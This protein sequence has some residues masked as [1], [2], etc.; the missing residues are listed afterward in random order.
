MVFNPPTILPFPPANGSPLPPPADVDLPDPDQPITTRD[1]ATLKIELGDG[2]AVID[3][4]P[5]QGDKP[6][7]DRFNANLALEMDDAE[8]SKISSD[9]L[10]GIQ[11][12][13]DSRTDQLAQLAKGIEL[14]GFVVEQSRTD[15]ATSTSPVE[16]MSTVRHPLLADACINFNATARGE[17]LPASGPVKVRD[18]R[19]S[20]PIGLGHNGGP[21]LEALPAATSPQLALGA[22]PGGV[23]PPA[24]AQPR[25]QLADA[26]EKDMN[27]Y[28]TTTASEYYPDTDQM[29]FRVG[30]GGWGIKKVYNCP[31]RRRPV[32]ES[33]N[34]DDFIVSN[35]A[36]D[37]GN[38]ARKTHRIKMR[39]STLRRMQILGVYRDD[40]IGEPELP[41]NQQNPVKEAI[42]QITGI[43]PMVQDRKDANHELDECYCELDL[44]KF[45]PTQFKNKGLPL[46][47]RV[48]IERSSKKIFE[49]RRNWKE[50]DKECR[51][52]EY[53][54]EFWFIKAFG[55]YGVGLLH[56]LGNTTKALTSIWRELIDAGS[57]AN[58]PGF[59][60]A[61]GAGRQLTNQFRVGPGQ[62]VGLDIGLQK[63]SDVVMALPYKD[64]SQAFSAFATHIEQLGMKLGGTAQIAVGEGRQD[65]PVGTTLALI[66]QATKPTSAVIKR[67]YSSQA[68]EMQ[69]LKERFREDPEAFWRFNSRPAMKWQKDQFLK[70]LDDFEL[71][72]VSDPNNPT[73]LH[74]A[75]KSEWVKQA[76]IAAGPG[77]VDPRKA[78][79]RS[80]QYVEVDD[81][82]DLLAA[83]LPPQQ[84]PVDPAKMADIAAKQEK[85]KTDAASAALK[86]QS[87]ITQAQMAHTA[88][89]AEI[90]A[91]TDLER[92][93]L[94][95]TMLIHSDKAEQVDRILHTK[96]AS[97][98]ALD[99]TR[100]VHE[101]HIQGRDHAHQAEQSDRDRQ[102]QLAQPPQEPQP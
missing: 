57:F 63:L 10:A 30:F 37:L 13:E 5:G 97:E 55:F 36:T 26:L 47:Y 54:V 99:T 24:G 50:D 28:L 46:P 12:D 65:A 7:S 27:H 87:D 70:A 100:R 73:H 22:I 95:Q 25:D 41:D 31:L 43:Q 18:D 61:K 77:V 11:S 72:P 96:L 76:A 64:V 56:I 88:R 67:L 16:D 38:A 101:M 49:L 62:G 83:P 75:A 91:E 44:D 19:P 58:F 40:K 45:A 69:L 21:P 84:P 74:R 68:K 34:T 33:I 4:N 89:M 6:K 20:T 1:G 78:F 2:S 53:F 29:T 92:M 51:E 82:E 42:S 39:H 17:L 9:L 52:R 102:T 8:L 80:A 48:T 3:F 23:S 60:Y 79:I 86:V 71:V 93:R 14:L 66:E 94:A 59:L 85:T 90:S 81:A 35:S 98:H 32:S 15:N